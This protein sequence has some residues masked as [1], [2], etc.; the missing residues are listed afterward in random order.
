MEFTC[1]AAAGVVALNE[2]LMTLDQIA[3]HLSKHDR[4]RVGRIAR[5]LMPFAA[6]IGM[7]CAPDVALDPHAKLPTEAGSPTKQRR[8]AR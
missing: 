4:Q 2:G 7:D 3:K 8:V 6:S 1:I 5:A